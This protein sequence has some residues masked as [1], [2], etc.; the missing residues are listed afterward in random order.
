MTGRSIGSSPILRFD[1]AFHDCATVSKRQRFF[2]RTSPHPVYPSEGT[3]AMSR[4]RT[5]PVYAALSVIIMLFAY[6]SVANAVGHAATCEHV[7]GPFSIVGARM[8]TGTGEP[9]IPY[10]VNLTD[11]VATDGSYEQ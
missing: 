3:N 8:V 11:L 2:I 9:F 4:I 7:S 6:F 10:G 1:S 5:V